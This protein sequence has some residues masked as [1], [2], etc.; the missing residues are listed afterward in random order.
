[1]CWPGKAGASLPFCVSFDGRRP[2]VMATCPS[3]TKCG[4]ERMP[5]AAT[6]E[7][8]FDA[9]VLHRIGFAFKQERIGILVHDVINL[10][11]RDFGL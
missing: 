7:L 10:T 8:L 4:T 5:A 9:F 3:L 1:M 6:E 11:H 2:P